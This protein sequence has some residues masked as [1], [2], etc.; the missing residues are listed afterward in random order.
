MDIIVTTPKSERAN[1]AAEARDC[2][3]AGNGSGAEY[4]RRFASQAAP[5]KL[6]VGERVYYVEDGYV[7]GYAI[8][9]RIEVRLVW[10]YC[11]TSGRIWPAGFYV[12]MPASSWRWIA[13]IAMRG[14]QGFRYAPPAG[15]GG[16]RR[17]GDVLDNVVQE[18]GGWLDP[19]PATATKGR[20]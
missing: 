11:E 3:A 20:P 7:R 16:E 12:F 13:P 15:V 5:R 6:R 17:L 1:A 8:V 4:F 2:I 18:I 9:S 14:F 19:M 10:L